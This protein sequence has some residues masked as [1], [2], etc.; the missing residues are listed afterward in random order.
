MSKPTLLERHSRKNT[1][2]I[3]VSTSEDNMF[4][5]RQ[6]VSQHKWPLI[7]QF[8]PRSEYLP[9]HAAELQQGCAETS[10]TC[11]MY[12]LV[13]SLSPVVLERAL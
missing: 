5:Q 2:G 7:R 6:E 4:F 9:L 13:L 12:K 1:R 11:Y 10:S 8:L 3:N